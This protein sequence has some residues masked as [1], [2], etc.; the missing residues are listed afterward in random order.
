MG[1]QGR[2][3]QGNT[4]S[5]KTGARATSSTWSQW[6]DDL[7]ITHDD[8]NASVAGPVAGQSALH[9]LL[10]VA[11]DLG[12]S[13]NSVIQAESGTVAS[14]Q[15]AGLVVRS[16]TMSTCAVAPAM[17]VTDRRCVRSVAPHYLDSRCTL[18]GIWIRAASSGRG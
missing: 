3:I 10:R 9:G 15:A 6:F 16:A 1:K 7:T 18:N 11:R 5:R 12:L 4:N 8:D 14:R 13:Q 17:L 2:Q